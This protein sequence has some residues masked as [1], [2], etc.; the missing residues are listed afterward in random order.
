MVSSPVA[1]PLPQDLWSFMK[2]LPPGETARGQVNCLRTATSRGPEA[3]VVFADRWD[4]KDGTGR[5]KR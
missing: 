1:L 2:I 5:K 3:H 4:T